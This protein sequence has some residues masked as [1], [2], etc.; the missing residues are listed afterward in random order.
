MDWERYIKSV[1]MYV[2]GDITETDLKKTEDRL[3]QITAVSGLSN[4][5]RKA[6]VKAVQQGRSRPDEN[7]S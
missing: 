3:F 7:E 1:K 2:D 5:V 4:K 6:M